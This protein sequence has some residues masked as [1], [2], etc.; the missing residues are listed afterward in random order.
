M[1][2]WDI[3]DRNRVTAGKTML[4]G[5][6]FADGAYHL[7]VQIC[8]FNSQGQMLIQQRQPFKDGWPGM[9]DITAGGSA[10]AG[11]SSQSAAQRELFEEIGYRMDF[12]NSRPHISV[13]FEKSYVDY[14]L[15]EADADVQKLQLQAEEVQKVKWAAKEEIL[16]M[17]EA[18]TFVPYYSSFLCLLFDM[19]RGYGSL[20]SDER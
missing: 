3:Y 10:V 16:C 13:S 14:Y 4:R 15:A 19:R 17:L 2:L 18:G 5:S 1:E 20:G 11:E 7:V 9:W 12:Q 8:I 6:S